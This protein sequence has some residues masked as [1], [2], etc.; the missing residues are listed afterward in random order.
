MQVAESVAEVHLFQTNV[1]FALGSA[2][3][4]AEEV[5]VELACLV[6]VG[7]GTGEVTRV[8]A[9]PLPANIEEVDADAA[10]SPTM[11]VA[12]TENV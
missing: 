3:Y 1:M 11:F 9:S 8:G 7:A 4:V 10:E 12:F 6:P 5:S 2:V